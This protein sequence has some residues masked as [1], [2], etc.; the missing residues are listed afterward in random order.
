[1]ITIYPSHLAK[2]DPLVLLVQVGLPP[3]LHIHTQPPLFLLHIRVWADWP[4]CGRREPL[5][6][7]HPHFPELWPPCPTLQSCAHVIKRVSKNESMQGCIFE[8]TP[9]LPH[10]LPPFSV[11]PLSLALPPFHCVSNQTSLILCFMDVLILAENRKRSRFWC[12]SCQGLA[13][14]RKQNNS[15]EPS[16][17]EVVTEESKL[18]QTTHSFPGLGS[19]RSGGRCQK[20]CSQPN[21][22]RELHPERPTED[23]KRQM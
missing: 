11:F 2:K 12:L 22:Q 23:R 6:T 15:S 7:S 16:L 21:I 8:L 10:V 18:P 9:L 4:C 19:G 13:P 14:E 17:F 5:L 1:M 3:L 20:T